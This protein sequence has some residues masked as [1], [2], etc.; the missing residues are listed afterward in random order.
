L[1]RLLPL[2][3]S[4]QQ[5]AI[6]AASSLIADFSNQF[7][8]S[9]LQMMAGKLGLTEASTQDDKLILDLLNHMEQQQLDYTITFNQLTRSLSSQ[10]DER[11]MSEELGNWYLRWRQTLEIQP[12]TTGEI[13]E[14]MRKA[15][16]LV[17]PR[18]HHMENV[19]S[20]C[21]E[22]GE[23]DTAEEFVEVLSSPYTKTDK[24]WLF[25]D[26]PKDADEGY[27]TFCGT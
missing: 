9:Y 7:Q 16:P 8:E 4:D 21:I 19:I 15:N 12:D 1:L 26:A 25:Q 22:S 18:N 20:T 3:D 17:I 11:T 5:Q 2:I 14:R 13:Q 23:A 24:T 10:S 6:D 27:Q